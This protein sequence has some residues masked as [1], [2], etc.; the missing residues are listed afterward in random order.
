MF[1]IGYGQPGE[2]AMREIDIPA[3]DDA[4]S[5][6]SIATE[7]VCF[8]IARIR[9]VDVKDLPSDPDSGSNPADDRQIDVLEDHP[10]DPAWAEVTATIDGMNL[11]EQIDLVAMMWLGRGDG[12]LDNWKDLRSEASRAHN[13][14]TASYLTEPPM[15]ADYLEEAL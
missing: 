11:D 10:D 6:Y 15:L 8:L 9:E 14:R 2:G 1:R 4:A 12:D 13:N 3:P 7:T 5:R